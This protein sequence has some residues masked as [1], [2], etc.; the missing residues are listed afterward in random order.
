MRYL[1]QPY[2]VSEN[3]IELRAAVFLLAGAITALAAGICLSQQ[4]IRVNS[5]LVDLAFTARDSHQRLVDNL[6]QDDIDVF[7]DGV[8]QNIAFF[9]RSVDVPLTLGLLVDDSPSQAHATQQ[10]EHDLDEFLRDVLGP[11]DRVFLVCFDNHIRLVSDFTQSRKELMDRFKRYDPE[12]PESGTIPE[13]GPHEDRILGTAFY[14]AIYNSVSDKLARETGRRALLVFSDGEDNSSSHNMMTTIESAQSSDVLIF[15]IRYTQDDYGKLTSRNKYGISVMD[16][17]A[18]ETGGLAFD[19]AVPGQDDYF[20]K[21]GQELRTAYEVGYYP[22]DTS[23]DDT[24]RKVVIRSK[25]TG[26]NLRSRPGY[27]AR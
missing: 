23:K 22:T 6:T 10:H 15:T 21:I 20:K 27:Y 1:P 3:L 17:I 7:E 24:F 13:L 14:D 16:R 2:K 19:A 12:K 26:I 5:S 25:R 8:L 11:K 9:A 18:K 4:P